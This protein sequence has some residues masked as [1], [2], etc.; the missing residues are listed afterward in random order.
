MSQETEPNL[1]LTQHLALNF[2]H[3]GKYQESLN[4]LYQA[5]QIR[6]D[7][8]DTQYIKA[9]IYQEQDMLDEAQKLYA[10][11]CEMHGAWNQAIYFCS[12]AVLLY[13]KNRCEEAFEKIIQATKINQ[14]M[15]ESWFNFGILYE[16]CK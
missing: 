7:D 6:Q 11:I 8:P 5:D 1:H 13:K 2:F 15:L 14:T 12:Y 4:R 9:R 10:S 3:Q 16:K